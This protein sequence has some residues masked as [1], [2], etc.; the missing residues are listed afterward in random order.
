VRPYCFGGHSSVAVGLTMELLFEINRPSVLA[1][2]KTFIQNHLPQWKPYSYLPLSEKETTTD[3]GY[4]IDFHYWYYATRALY[5]MGDSRD[6]SKKLQKVL[7]QGTLQY[8]EE[9]GSIQ[10][11]GIWCRV[12]GRFYSTIMALML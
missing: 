6:F 8:G 9:C 10:P 12:G 5:L 2:G 1:F 7:A 11:E 3:Q 4:L